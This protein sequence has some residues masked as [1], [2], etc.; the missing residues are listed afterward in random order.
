MQKYSIRDKCYINTNKDTDT[1]VGI[2]CEDNKFSVHFPLGFGISD[3]EDGLRKDIMLVINSIERT[4]RKKESFVSERAKEFETKGFPVSAYL[5]LISDYYE[6]GYYKE[7]D[8]QYQI[9]NRGKISWGRT[10]KT[11]KPYIQNNAVYYLKFVTRK[12]SVNSNELITLIHEYCVYDSFSKMG[13]LFTGFLPVKPQIKFNQKLFKMLV[14]EKLQQTF[15]DQKKL[16]FKNMLAVIDNLNDPDTPMNFKYGTYRFEY[17]WEAM[18]DRVY[19]IKE[20]SFYF[21]K[22]SWHLS[23]QSQDNAA[24]EPDSIMIWK[25][26]IYVLDA[27]YYKY[28][29]TRKVKDLPGSTSVNKQITY[30]EYIATE[31]KFRGK[32]GE[33]YE[34]YNAFLMPYNSADLE[35]LEHIGEAV[36]DWKTGNSIYERIQ[37]ILVDVKH[38]MGITTREDESEIIKLAECIN[39][40]LTK[41]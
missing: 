34:V 32:Y 27:K 26:N 20:K 21:P 18:I 24:L 36:S 38:L 9:S 11:Q 40:S 30:G 1:F 37:G 19:G 14:Q 33:N 5:F 15:N 25:G 3:D 35:W 28:G 13:W 10:V 6:N 41:G 8:V 2:K 39:S 7:K 4:T 31:E 29:I 12:N 17:V 22:T 23:G 16:R